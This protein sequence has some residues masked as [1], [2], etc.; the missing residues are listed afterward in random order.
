MSKTQNNLND[1]QNF[2]KEVGERL[3]K[4]IDETEKQYKDFAEE[5]NIPATTLSSHYKGKSE[6]GIEMLMMYAKA[7]NVSADYLL[8]GEEQTTNTQKNLTVDAVF[9]AIN[10]LLDVFDNNIIQTI[11]LEYE[12]FSG[13]CLCIKNKYIQMYLERITNI[14]KLKD[15]CPAETYTFMRKLLIPKEN[16]LI[17]KDGIEN[18]DDLPF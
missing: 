16:L 10:I 4:C 8:F 18:S 1:K 7:L 6:M 15:C 3:K 12:Q 11:Y 9:N 2:I 13:L 17:T 14:A 5:L